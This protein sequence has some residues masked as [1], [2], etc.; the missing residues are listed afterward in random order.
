MMGPT[1]IHYRKT[2]ASASYLF[3]AF[4]MIGHCKE[5]EWLQAFGTDGEK[6]LIDAF[7][8]EFPFAVH[9]TCFIHV[10]RNVK[11]ESSKSSLS[12]DK[13]CIILEDIFGK[14]AGA[15]LCEGLV[16]VQSE[17][18]FNEKFEIVKMKWMKWE[19]SE[20]EIQGFATGLCK[21]G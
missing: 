16:D 18:E 11:D 5:I 10:R 21:T 2:F 1:L 14:K 3:F 6:A 15:I 13:Q 12:H 9:R 20:E 17:A 8:H 4:S 7:T 19:D